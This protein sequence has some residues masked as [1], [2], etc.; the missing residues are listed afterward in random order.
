MYHQDSPSNMKMHLSHQPKHGLMSKRGGKIPT[1]EALTRNGLRRTPSDKDRALETP[2]CLGECSAIEDI[3]RDR[4]AQKKYIRKKKT[5]RLLDNG[6]GAAVALS[7]CRIEAFF[8][9]EGP[10]RWTLSCAVRYCTL[11]LCRS[12]RRGSRC[13]ISIIACIGLWDIY[14]KHSSMHVISTSPRASSLS[15]NH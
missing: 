7:A 6:V 9:I 13:V 4:A 11:F 1:Y 15:Q 2:K 12:F 10:E 5:K 3:Y 14:L 8:A